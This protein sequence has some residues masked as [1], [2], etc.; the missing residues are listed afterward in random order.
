MIRAI[1]LPSAKRDLLQ[2]FLYIAQASGSR[3][4]SRRFISR[5]RAHCHHLA[6]LPFQMGVS[7]TDLAPDLRSAIFEKYVIF[8]RYTEDSLDMI[9]IIEGHRDLPGYFSTTRSECAILASRS[10]PNPRTGLQSS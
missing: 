9:D 2:L 7:R 1:F 4:V 3:T 5:L 6:S 8:L 10:L